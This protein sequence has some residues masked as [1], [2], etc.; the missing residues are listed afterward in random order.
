MMYEIWEAHGHISGWPCESCHSWR[1]SIW[2]WGYDH[3]CPNR[4]I[5][6]SMNDGDEDEIDDDD[7]EEEDT[8]TTAQ[9]EWL[10]QLP[11]TLH[12]KTW[13][14]IFCVEG[15]YSELRRKAQNSDF[16]WGP[17][18]WW[19]QTFKITN[20]FFSKYFRNNYLAIFMKLSQKLNSTLFLLSS[21]K[22]ELS[23]SS[24]KNAPEYL[25]ADKM[26]RSV[27]KPIWNILRHI[28]WEAMSR[29]LEWT[30]SISLSL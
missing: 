14:L 25:D 29:M 26:R 19:N 18:S 27:K 28:K 2:S 30:L 7:D 1:N 12:E 10:L 20:I 8:N 21:N 4:L 6:T 13:N 24:H 16:H 11:N 5:T 9:T 23:I 22:G 15:F 3:H 17:P